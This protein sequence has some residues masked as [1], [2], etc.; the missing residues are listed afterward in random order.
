M[1]IDPTT[2]NKT[3]LDTLTELGRALVDADVLAVHDGVDLKK[4]LVS[5]IKAYLAP[6]GGLKYT[7]LVE[8]PDGVRTSFTIPVTIAPLGQWIPQSDGVAVMPENFTWDGATGTFTFT[9]A[10]ASG[11][12]LTAFGSSV[13]V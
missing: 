8:A 4:M 11:I 2:T 13:T 6:Q 1:P 7:D 3:T 9:A 12:R 5:R 10:P